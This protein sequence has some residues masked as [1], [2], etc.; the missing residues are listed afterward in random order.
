[1]D[2]GRPNFAAIN[3]WKQKEKNWSHLNH[4]ICHERSVKDTLNAS[5]HYSFLNDYEGFTAEDK[6]EQFKEM[7]TK[8]NIEVTKSCFDCFQAALT[9]LMHKNDRQ[10]IEGQIKE[11][12]A[13]KDC[14]HGC[15]TTRAYAS[16]WAAAGKYHLEEYEHAESLCA[17]TLTDVNICDNDCRTV[18]CLAC[19]D[20]LLECF[21]L[22]W[23]EKMYYVSFELLA[24]YLLFLCKVRLSK[25]GEAEDLVLYIARKCDKVL[26]KDGGCSEPRHV[27]SR[28]R[29]MA[30]KWLFI[31]KF[32][33]AHIPKA[34]L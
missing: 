24:R 2:E 7:C 32:V 30:L 22:L 27:Y 16:L 10:V 1:M 15:N 17:S 26:R 28:L 5:L 14:N 33:D 18:T 12:L 34:T 19:V 13:I 9:L 20:H 29:T 3:E 31:R 23:H 8:V 25:L 4:S 11:L 6:A 21:D